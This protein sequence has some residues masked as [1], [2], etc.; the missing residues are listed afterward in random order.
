MFETKWQTGFKYVKL[1]IISTTLAGS[2]SIYIR[3]YFYKIGQ[4]CE[5]K[6]V[7]IRMEYI[8]K[9]T[10]MCV[11]WTKLNTGKMIKIINEGQVTNICTIMAVVS[12]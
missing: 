10:G 11:Q 12:N 7:E 2:I 9:K 4:I 6:M 8:L 1:S 3:S 5:L